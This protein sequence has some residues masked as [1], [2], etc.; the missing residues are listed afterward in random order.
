VTPSRLALVAIGPIGALVTLMTAR[1]M[2]AAA[3]LPRPQAQRT[4]AFALLAIATGVIAVA[5]GQLPV[6]NR[7][8]PPDL[9]ASGLWRVAVVPGGTVL[10][11]PA[12]G[13]VADVLGWQVATNGAF[14]LVG[15]D[16]LS[17]G[18]DHSGPDVESTTQRML[19]DVWLTGEE[20]DITADHQR[21]SREDL[22]AL[23]VSAIIVLER[24]HHDAVVRVLTELLQAPA[25]PVGGTWTWRI[26]NGTA[27]RTTV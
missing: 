22:A 10:T 24:G 1:A 27:I 25:L 21:R 26:A 4:R 18:T 8:A 7:P 9:I 17:P 16:A 13:T 11:I 6:E 12:P 15:M 3:D 20:P 23:R 19:A 2:T 14:A 5:P